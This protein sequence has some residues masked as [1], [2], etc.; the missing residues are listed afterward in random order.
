MTIDPRTTHRAWP[1]AITRSVRTGFRIVVAPDFLVEAKQH[2]LLADAAGGEVSD[3]VVYRREYHDRGAE[4]LWLLYRVVYLKK[5]D[6]GLGD[7][8][9]RR[10]R[11]T[12][13]IEGLVL[14]TRPGFE[15]TGELFALVH[16]ACLSTVREFYLED[17]GTFPVHRSEELPEVPDT[18]QPLR[19]KDQ[20]PYVSER[21]L[22]AALPG[23]R[24]Q[25]HPAAKPARVGGTPGAPR[26]TDDGR[27]GPVRDGAGAGHRDQEAAPVREGVGSGAA[28]AAD[29]R[30]QHRASWLIP[31]LAT[32]AVV[33]AVLL[34][35]CLL[36]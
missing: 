29:G 31:A 7:E 24:L 21:N 30:R 13:L 36:H 3:E 6:V 8:F 1:F 25:P 26:R 27:P 35:V 18:G 20:A 23:R 33:L 14:R 12:P 34:L 22:E 9:D 19:I 2:S 10:D 11:R 17:S 32:V 5:E 28:P 15:A 16:E 4:R